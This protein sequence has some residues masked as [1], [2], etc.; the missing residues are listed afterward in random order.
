MSFTL[1]QKSN[2]FHKRKKRLWNGRIPPQNMWRETHLFRF[3]EHETAPLAI[4]FLS[5][6][7]SLHFW[8]GKPSSFPSHLRARV[9][10][11]WQ[12]GDSDPTRMEEAT[13]HDPT[14]LFFSTWRLRCVCLDQRRGN[15]TKKSFRCASLLKD[16]YD[17]LVRKQQQREWTKIEQK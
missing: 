13:S 15:K 16:L 3:P 12:F 11:G 9:G 14:K 6:K 5:Q 7:P 17:C 2:N 10:L 8:M 1:E 4:F